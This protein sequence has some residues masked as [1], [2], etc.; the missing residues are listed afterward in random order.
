MKGT[1]VSSRRAE[2]DHLPLA[3]FGSRA[4]QSHR[5]GYTLVFFA[6]IMF[7]LMGL[8]AL[9]IDI[10]FARLTQRQMQTAVDSA[11]LEGLRWRDVNEW[12]EVPMGWLGDPAFIA[13]FDVNEDF[14]GTITN[15]VDKE[16][17][18][19]WAAQQVV[20]GTFDDDLESGNGDDGA[21]DGGGQFG[22]GPV[23]ELSGGVG[24]PILNA[25]QLLT[26]PA[27]P[28]YKPV[29]EQNLGN[30]IHGDMVAGAYDGAATIH[31]EDS[32]YDRTDFDLTG[33]DAFLVRLRRTNDFEGLDNVAGESSSGPPLPYLFGRGSLL[34]FRDPA[35]TYSPRHQGMTVRATGIAD[36]RSVVRLGTSNAAIVLAFAVRAAD[37][38]DL[39]PQQPSSL[40]LV[41]GQCGPI[42]AAR[43]Q[44]G[45]TAELLQQTFSGSGYISIIHNIGGQDRVI[46]FGHAEVALDSPTTLLVEKLV[47]AGGNG[48]MIVNGT[49]MLASVGETLESLSPVDRGDLLSAIFGDNSANTPPILT[50]PLLAPVSVR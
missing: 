7:A 34:A 25:S 38:K 8:A 17:I 4:M 39:P 40:S 32:T 47:D 23:V 30:E 11:A 6:M 15:D 19:R 49:A 21:F 2:R 48:T 50:D 18:R 22:A 26:T 1:R 33:D 29:V 42:A 5:G 12:E 46:G 41:T 24:E 14:I 43:F 44:V 20:L 16:R 37:W 27:T 45:E 36:A 3:P 28:F 31:D 10:G 35:T 13:L 9:V